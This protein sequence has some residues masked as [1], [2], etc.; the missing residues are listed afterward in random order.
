MKA[1]P[2]F[3]GSRATRTKVASVHLAMKDPKLIQTKQAI[4]QMPKI[5]RMEHPPPPLPINQL[6]QLQ[7]GLSRAAAHPRDVP[8]HPDVAVRPAKSLQSLEQTHAFYHA[9]F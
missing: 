5:A 2:L 9:L 7:T 8:G 1:L 4:A 6:V 3:R